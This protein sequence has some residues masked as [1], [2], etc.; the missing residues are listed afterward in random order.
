MQGRVNQIDTVLASYIKFN[1]DEKK[2]NEFLKK[3]IDKI[4]KEEDGKPIKSS[5]KGNKEVTK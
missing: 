2:F 1:K 3:S 4:S 5:N